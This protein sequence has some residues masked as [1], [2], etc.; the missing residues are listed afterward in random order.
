MMIQTGHYRMYLS[1]TYLELSGSKEYARTRYNLWTE[2]NKHVRPQ[3]IIHVI[4]ENPNLMSNNNMVLT[5]FYK[6]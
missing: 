5:Q 2:P 3:A 4:P 1:I 6:K